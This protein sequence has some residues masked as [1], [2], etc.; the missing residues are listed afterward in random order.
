MTHKEPQGWE[1]RFR[2]KFQSGGEHQI[3][4]SMVKGYN[5][6]GM[7]LENFIKEVHS[8][9]YAL[10]GEEEGASIKEKLEKFDVTLFLRNYGLDDGEE[11]KAEDIAEMC[12]S[13]HYDILSLT[14]TKDKEDSPTE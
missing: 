10:G 11:M 5:A 9:A 2:E 7:S 14:T 6:A 8:T 1:E 13:M 4:Y 12:E 3:G